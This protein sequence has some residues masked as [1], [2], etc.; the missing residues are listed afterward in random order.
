MVNTRRR[1]TAVAIAA[2]ML[3]LVTGV[4]TAGARGS[5]R[6]GLTLKQP[7]AFGGFT[8]LASN[9]TLKD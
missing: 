4:G 7:V 5:V 1:S 2:L 6:S 9:T 8:L 3:T